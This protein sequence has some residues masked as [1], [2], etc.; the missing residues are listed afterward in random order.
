MITWMQRHKKWLVIT[1]WISTIA[2]V[3][4]GFVGWGS[5]DYGSKGGVVAKVG[6]KEVTVDEYQQE[7]SNLY[8]E[9]ARMFGPMFS[10]ELAE[11][12]K[13]KDIAFKKVLEKNLIMSYGDSLGLVS[14]DEEVA[15]ELIKYEVFQKDGKFDKE[16]YIKVLNQNK[17]APKDFEESL[18]NQ[19]LLQKTQDLFVLNP[20]QKE[21]ENL[22]KLLFIED[23]ITIKI[24]SLDDVKVEVKDEELK[25][26]HEA[27]K[28]RY[29]SEVSYDL[30]MKT[31]PLVPSN[32]T[33]D[34]IKAQYDK[35]KSDYKFE[36][37]KIKSFEE[38]KGQ[39]IADLDEKFTK[40]EALSLYLKLKKDEEKFDKKENFVE[41]KLPF[42][43]ENLE[44]INEVKNGE[45][46]KPF[47]E[48][49][50]YYIVKLVNKKASTPLSF[51]EAKEQAILDFEKELKSKKLDEVANSSLEG[52]TG[53]NI[54]GV[55][56][57]TISKIPAL[58]QQEAANF[59]NQ[60]F[61]ATKKEGVIR[62]ENK[63][64]LYRINNSKMAAYDKS[65][66]ELVKNA[67]MQVQESDLIN[68]LLKKLETIYTIK[69]S[70][71]TK[72]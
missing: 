68:N 70:I 52:F 39:V 44:K 21:I 60:L 37:G 33:E 18:K 27:N 65:K 59:L 12:L 19:I 53:D 29:L 57:E 35:F 9:Y 64:I 30:E 67:V 14:T 13:L 17:L 47:F 49:N 20:S 48:N 43:P 6:S 50:N 31:I 36:D 55:T 69:T 66:D 71:Q 7:Y 63:A 62:L 10:K 22:S 5:Y 51:E 56:R 2:F 58:A 34:E 8:N 1:I 38:A 40:K 46:V 41:S 26:Y 3:G 15:K 28:N 32:P 23:D 54:N 45:I 42:L 16:T 4:A 25:T 24:L 11:Q 72:E 61:S